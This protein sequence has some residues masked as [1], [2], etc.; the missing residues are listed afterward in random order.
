MMIQAISGYI[1]GTCSG[2]LLMTIL[3]KGKRSDG[4]A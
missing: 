1:L 4:N 3:I 2:V